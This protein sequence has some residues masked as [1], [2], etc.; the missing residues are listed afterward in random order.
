M[1]VGRYKIVKTTKYHSFPV[2][3]KRN[4]RYPKPKRRVIAIN[5]KMKTGIVFRDLIS[6]VAYLKKNN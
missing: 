6:F 5:M 4:I 3:I 2:F 1:Y